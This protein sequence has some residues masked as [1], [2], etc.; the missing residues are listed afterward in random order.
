MLLT[1]AAAAGQSVTYDG[2]LSFARGSYIFTEPTQS[3]WLTNGLSFRTGRLLL[4]GS[5]PVVVQNSGIISFVAGQ[6]IGTGGEDADAV[7]RRNKGE[8]VGTRGTHEGGGAV[9]RSPAYPQRVEDPA[10]DDS[11]TVFFRGSYEVEVGDP[12][13]YGSIEL[14]S[15]SGALR[16]VGLGLSAKAP[17]R[18]VESGVGTGAWD[19]GAGISLAAGSGRNLLLADMAYWTYGDLPDLELDPGW[20]WGLSLSR[21]FEEGRVAVSGTFSGATAMVATAEP[22]MSIGLGLMLLPRMGRVF[23]AGLW[24]GLSEAAPDISASLGWSLRLRG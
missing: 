9:G 19:V 17:L 11:T 2:S 4:S 7:G 10:D 14:Y 3:F 1:A 24:F 22:P 13:L 8:P 15:G 20:M 18:S 23:S 5:L 12:L 16:S 6:P 21:S